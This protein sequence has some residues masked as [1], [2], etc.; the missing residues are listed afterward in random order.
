[1]PQISLL[2]RCQFIHSIEHTTIVR[3]HIE[4]MAWC[5]YKCL[6]Q[7]FH[8]SCTSP[9]KHVK[10]K[11]SQQHHMIWWIRSLWTSLLWLSWFLSHIKN[12]PN[13]A[14]NS[15]QSQQIIP[16]KIHKE[17]FG[18]VSLLSPKLLAISNPKIPWSSQHWIV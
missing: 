14:T 16:L 5:T 4:S 1:M 18:Y 8:N 3:V 11:D 6:T 13:S 15:Q 12:P 7:C 2:Y 9:T 10:L 17:F